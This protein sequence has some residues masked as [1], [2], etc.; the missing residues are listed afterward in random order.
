MEFRSL[1]QYNIVE[2][3]D[4]FDRCFEDYV[5]PFKITHQSAAAHIRRDGVDLWRS[6]AVLHQGREV[7]IAYLAPR[8]DKV[9]L[10]GMGVIKEARGQGVGR[11]AV[12]EFLRRCR[13]DNF[14]EAVLEVF[15][16]NISAVRLYESYGFKV[17]QRLYGYQRGPLEA[18]DGEELVEVDPSLYIDAIRSDRGHST[19]GQGP[20]HACAMTLPVRCWSNGQA[21]ACFAPPSESAPIVVSGFA[22]LPQH[23]GQGCGRRMIESIQ[24]SFPGRSWM[25]PQ[26]VPE[27][28]D[29]F[30]LKLGF[31]RQALNQFAMRLSL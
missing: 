8:F 9:R 28:M 12:V 10:A 20:E 3:A 16:Q 19:H 14:Q 18:P 13:S 21:F 23:R 6:F 2:I 27:C 24:R 5:I 7:G 22:V 11:A 1:H 15:E 17:M 29:G 26:V 31:Q 25:I 4:L 30:F